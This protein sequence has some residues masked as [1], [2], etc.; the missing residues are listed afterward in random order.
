M[1]FFPMYNEESYFFKP[2]NFYPFIVPL[3]FTHVKKYTTVLFIY[4]PSFSYINCAKY[5][6]SKVTTNLLVTKVWPITEKYKLHVHCFLTYVFPCYNKK[7]PVC[8][9]FTYNASLPQPRFW[10]SHMY[11]ETT[12]SLQNTYAHVDITCITT[13]RLISYRNW[14]RWQSIRILT[15][16]YNGFSVLNKGLTLSSAIFRQNA[17][18][19]FVVFVSM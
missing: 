13:D 10:N 16:L 2:E 14:K 17:K 15:L 18:W 5:L 8:H 6:I 11:Q 9:R 3:D 12:V 7:C 4:F 1:Y 19:N